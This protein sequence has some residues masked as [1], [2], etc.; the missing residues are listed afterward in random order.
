MRRELRSAIVSMLVFTV[1]TGL[2]YPLAMTG[3]AQVLFPR[4]AQ[5]SLINREGHA[6]GSTLIGQPF[7]DAKYFWGRPSATSP[8]SYNA[9]S[10]SGSILGPTS[11]GP[12]PD[13]GSDYQCRPHWHALTGQPAFRRPS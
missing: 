9:S 8:Y 4:Q 1:L 12:Q 7:D 2:I 5:G 13:A 11:A 6:I 10:S 3:L